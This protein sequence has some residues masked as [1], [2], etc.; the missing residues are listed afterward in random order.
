MIC[1][2]IQDKDLETCKK[3]MQGIE[4]AEI[5]LDLTNLTEPEVAELF[6]TATIPLIATCRYDNF[7]DEDRM[8]LLKT[9]IK[10]GAAFVDLEIEADSDFKTEMANFAKEFNCRVILSY[11]NY[12]NTPSRETLQMIINQ[13]MR[14][15][16]DIVK[17]ATTA[18]DEKDSARVLGLYE[19]NVSLVALAM[20]EKGKITRLAAV[21]LGAPFTF[22]SKTREQATAP[23]QITMN[24]LELIYSKLQ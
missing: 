21:K 19:K 7:S 20:G 12:K 4:M 23:G 3:A 10:N 24:D 2:C 1:V 6:S 14:E 17:L 9:A 18:A 11:H 13:C 5:R 8:T 22:A 16:A 15:G